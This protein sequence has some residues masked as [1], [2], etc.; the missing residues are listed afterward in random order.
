MALRGK[1]T[2]DFIPIKEIRNGVVIL[3]DGGYRSVLMASSINF[4]LKSPDEQQAVIS[5][6]QNFLNVLEFSV[7]IY[8]QSRKLDIQPY[9]NLLE[10]RMKVQTSDLMKIQTHEYIEFVKKF[11]DDANIMTKTFYVVVPYDPTPDLKKTGFL[12]RILPSSGNKQ[13]AEKDS[14]EEHRSQLEQR[15][16]I[17]EQGLSRT[18]VRVAQL[19]TEELIELY[20]KIFN[21][22]EVDKP[23][24]YRENG[25]Q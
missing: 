7:Q 14:I 16:S 11:V 20:Y 12:S 21:P 5:Q 1:P 13:E 23:M 18:G 22:G 17:V 9:V 10:E 2:Q 15:T 24:Q 4:A 25:N 8:V 6:F 3:K 19:G